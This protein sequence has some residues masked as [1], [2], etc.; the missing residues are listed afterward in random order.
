M[1]ILFHVCSSQAPL[2]LVCLTVPLAEGGLSRG[3]TICRNKW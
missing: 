1:K 2:H 3:S